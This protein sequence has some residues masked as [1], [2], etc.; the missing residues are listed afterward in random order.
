MPL[1]CPYICGE[2]AFKDGKK[3]TENPY[4]PSTDNHDDWKDGWINARDENDDR[5]DR[6]EN[7]QAYR[8]SFVDRLFGL[9]LTS[10]V[11]K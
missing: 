11:R 8:R 2:L 5:L 1:M 10:S 9:L 6:L 3:V 7:E 4:M